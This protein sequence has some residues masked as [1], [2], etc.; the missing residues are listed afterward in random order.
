MKIEYIILWIVFLLKDLWKKAVP[1]VDGFTIYN[2]ESLETVGSIFLSI[3]TGV[4]IIIGMRYIKSLREKKLAASFSFWS[5]IKLKIIRLQNYLLWNKEIINNFYNTESRLRW[6]E[7]E[8]SMDQLN[9]FKKLVIDVLEYL[10][11]TPDQMPA[12]IGWSED[13]MVLMDFLTKVIQYDIC[14][15]T[16]MFFS[17]EIVDKKERDVYYSNV[18]NA[19]QSLISGIQN[20]QFELEKKLFPQK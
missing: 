4:S 9:D 16:N 13:M 10:D 12:Y 8:V 3:V 1:Y 2:Y 19:I 20:G 18:C 11:K 14:N 17:N 5:Q 15:N 6:E 7:K